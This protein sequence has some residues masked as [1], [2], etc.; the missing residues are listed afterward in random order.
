M[1]NEKRLIDANALPIKFDGHTVSVWKCDIESAPTV[2][3]AE[4]VHGKWKYYHK[5]NIAVCTNC[6]FERKL[7]ADFGKAISC[8]NCGAKMD[9]G[10]EK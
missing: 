7:D 8:P 6:S 1:A 4:V 10:N 2:D 3:A 5:H 9:G